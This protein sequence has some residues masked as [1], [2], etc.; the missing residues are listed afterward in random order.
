MVVEV[1]IYFLNF[2][3]SDFG[4]EIHAQHFDDQLS[5]YGTYAIHL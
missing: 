3:Y 5:V 4:S 2:Y 1:N